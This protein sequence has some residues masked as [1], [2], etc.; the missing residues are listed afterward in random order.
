M[1]RLW[2]RSSESLAGSATPFDFFMPSERSL[3]YGKIAEGRSHVERHLFLGIVPVLLAAF[4]V[5]RRQSCRR[6]R[7]S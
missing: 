5:W 3:L 4:S 7:L 2:R 6:L 1:Y